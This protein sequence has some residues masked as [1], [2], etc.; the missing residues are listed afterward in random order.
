MGTHGAPEPRHV[1]C[2]HLQPQPTHARADTASGS[3]TGAAR[4]SREQHPYP[5]GDQRVA[6]RPRAASGN[7][8]AV[9]RSC[10]T[11]AGGCRPLWCAP[12]LRGAATSRNRHSY[13]DWRAGP[14]YRATYYRGHLLNG[15]GGSA[16]GPRARYELDTIRR[17][18]VLSSEGHRPAHACAY[19][20]GNC[21][22]GAASVVASGNPGGANRPRR[23]AAG[24]IGAPSCTAW[25]LPP[26]RPKRSASGV[27]GLRSGRGPVRCKELLRPNGPSCSENLLPKAIPHNYHSRLTW[28][29]RNS[30]ACCPAFLSAAKAPG[31]ATIWPSS[32]A[33]CLLSCCIG[34]TPFVF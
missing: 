4:V 8:G 26:L 20:A 6:N 10:R 18:A 34:K 24:G 14:R 29:V 21:R 16:R 30:P 23:D 11:V 3:A 22:G 31:V 19:V 32:K 12:L 1:H 13:G 5:T 17:D 25:P 27:T 33:G 15:V 9:F 28:R 2:T 7:A